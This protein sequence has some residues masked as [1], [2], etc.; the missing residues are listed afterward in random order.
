MAWQLLAKNSD[1]EGYSPWDYSGFKYQQR[2]VH[3]IIRDCVNGLNGQK[4]GG[5]VIVGEDSL[6]IPPRESSSLS[7]NNILHLILAR[8]HL[9]ACPPQ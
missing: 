5:H 9:P 2:A 6:S 8:V 1:A 7:R 3:A 4:S